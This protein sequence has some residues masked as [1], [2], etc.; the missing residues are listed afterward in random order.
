MLRAGH[1]TYENALCLMI[2]QSKM[3]NV[4]YINVSDFSEKYN[5]YANHD[6]STIQLSVM[7][8]TIAKF[9]QYLYQ[10][11]LHNLTSMY[12]IHGNIIHFKCY[13]I[14]SYI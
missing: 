10:A 8:H 2:Q 1:K 13:I 4:P 9:M 3:D 11:L 12:P 5:L 7:R 6:A 14:Y